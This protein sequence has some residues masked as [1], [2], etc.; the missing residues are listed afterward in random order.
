MITQSH[1]T[2]PSPYEA[3]QTAQGHENAAGALRISLYDEGS[4]A[5]DTSLAHLIEHMMKAL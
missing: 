1:P 2:P 4:D 3:G 5:D